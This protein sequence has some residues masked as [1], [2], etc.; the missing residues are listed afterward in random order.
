L[1]GKKD[2]IVILIGHWFLHAFALIALTEWSKPKLDGPLFLLVF[3]PS[4]FYIMTVQ[5]S[6]PSNFK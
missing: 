4:L 6:D 1:L 2:I 3:L 5:L